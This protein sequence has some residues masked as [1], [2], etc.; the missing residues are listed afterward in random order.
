MG[1]V[2]D[3]TVGELTGSNRAAD[4]AGRAAQAQ[5]GAQGLAVDF[6][7][8]GL[9]NARTRQ[10]SIDRL[11]SQN[12]RTSQNQL[13]SVSSLANRAINAANSP[14]ELRAL[15][16]ALDTQ[17]RALGRQMELFESIDPAVMAASEQ[18]LQLLQG[19]E[20]RALAPIRQE[21]ETQ[22]QALVDRLREQLGPGAETSTAGIQALNRFDQ[23]T[24]QVMAGAQQQSLSQLFGIASAGAQGR[25]ALNEGTQGVAGIGQAF[26]NAAARQATTR[27]GALGNVQGAM[28]NV[29]SAQQNRASNRIAGMGVEQTAFANLINAQS[30]LAA[31]SGSEFVSSQLRG[32]AQNQF[33]NDRIQAG[34]QMVSQGMRMAAGGGGKCD[35]TAKENIEPLTN[36]IDEFLS[37]LNPYEYTYKDIEDGMGVQYGIMA[38]DLEKSEI[39]RKYVFKPDGIDGAKWVDFGKM[40]PTMLATMARMHKRIEE[41]EERLGG[42]A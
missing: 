42:K 14:Q 25:S 19:E 5:Q 24:S 29:L 38:Q 33:V 32:Q 35:I 21:R 4:A 17:Q 39:G 26:G 16:Q 27:L 7:R 23:E 11:D 13:R 9:A 12:V 6:A 10:G 41:L 18:A 30:G 28:G 40:M 36:K 37:N 34:E 1:E 31:V 22:R 2:Y 20:A 8:E 3:A 15:T